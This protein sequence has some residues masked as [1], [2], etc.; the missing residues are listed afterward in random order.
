MMSIRS[1]GI[2]RQK[3]QVGEIEREREGGQ[4]RGGGDKKRQG[5]DTKT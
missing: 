3:R 5:G 4:G 1:L 2:E